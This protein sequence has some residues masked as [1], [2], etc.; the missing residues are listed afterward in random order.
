MDTDK[1]AKQCECVDRLIVEDE[2]FEVAAVVVSRI[3]GRADESGADGADVILNFRVIHEC[4]V[5]AHFQHNA[6]A[7]RA[8][9]RSRKY[10]V[11]NIA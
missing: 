4:A 11:G 2:K 6:L 1:T 10:R 3:A 8:L 9:L 5:A 7:D